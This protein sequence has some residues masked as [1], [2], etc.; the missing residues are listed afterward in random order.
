MNFE[1][2]MKQEM[3]HFSFRAG[4]GPNQWEQMR[5]PIKPSR[6]AKERGDKA[7]VAICLQPSAPEALEMQGRARLAPCGKRG[8]ETAARIWSSSAFCICQNIVS[9]IRERD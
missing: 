1:G 9:A 4:A 2:E 7:L 6:K 3:G 8:M 5:F